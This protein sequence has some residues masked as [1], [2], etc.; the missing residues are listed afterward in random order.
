MTEH[1]EPRAAGPEPP[2]DLNSH[3][4]LR[5][6]SMWALKRIDDLSSWRDAYYTISSTLAKTLHEK[7]LLQGEIVM[8]KTR[9]ARVDDGVDWQSVARQRAREA[10]EIGAERDRLRHQVERLTPNNG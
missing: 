10:D 7:E 9:L 8:L 3:K 2:L 5:R 6:W 1:K 4:S